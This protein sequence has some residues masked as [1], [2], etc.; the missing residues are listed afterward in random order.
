MASKFLSKL[1]LSSRFFHKH[2]L[3]LDLRRRRAKIWVYGWRARG[4][5]SCT[6]TSGAPREM[7][8]VIRDSN[9]NDD[10][11]QMEL[12]QFSPEG[13]IQERPRSVLWDR[14]AVFIGLGKIKCFK[15][16]IELLKD[17]KPFGCPARRRWP[18]EENS[19][20]KVMEKHLEM[21]VFAATATP[22]AACNVFVRNT[23]GSDRVTSNSG[24]QTP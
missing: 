3:I 19:E 20:R 21:R 12:S 18:A 22:C 6:T 9:V 16:K 15:H 23:D 7:E 1:L 5:V 24:V 8:A 11:N 4:K 14:R 10:I 13:Y 2:I 17:S